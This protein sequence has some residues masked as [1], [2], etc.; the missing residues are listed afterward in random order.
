MK[1]KLLVIAT[2]ALLFAQHAVTVFWIEHR[3]ETM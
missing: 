1:S 3:K 2:T